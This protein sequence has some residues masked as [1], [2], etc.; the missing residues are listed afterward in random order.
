MGKYFGTD[1]IRG[2]ANN[3]L[4][5]SLAFKIGKAAA[6]VMSR[7]LN[8]R[9]VFLIG[10][11]T[12]ISGDML[13]AA[14]TA[15][16]CSAGGDVFIAGVIPTP[17][18]AFFVKNS[19]LYDSGIVISASHN[20]FYDNGI[21]FFDTNGCKLNDNIE[22]EIEHYIQ[23]EQSIK[24]PKP[25]EIGTRQI[26]LNAINEYKD[27]L[28]KSLDTQSLKGFK[29]VIDCANGATSEVAPMVFKELFADL[30]VVFDKPNGTNIN[31]NCGST[32]MERLQ[33]EVKDQKADL[34]IAYDGDGDRTLL[35][36]ENGQLIDG[37]KIMFIVANYLQKQNKLKNKG[38]VATVMSNYGLIQAAKEKD[39][40]LELSNVGD[41]YVL[42]KI[43]EKDYNFG[44][45]QSG[46]IIFFDY[47][48]S[49]DGIFTSIQLLNIM[50]KTNEK[51][52]KL[53]NEMN[54]MP[55]VLV[56]VKVSDNKKNDYLTN[57]VIC[58]KIK[59]VEKHLENS[60][61]ILV[62]ASGTE[63]LIRIMIE[64][65][66]KDYIIEEANKIAMLLQA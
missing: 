18:I 38:F 55:Q 32:H 5:P 13:E 7:S 28:K 34:G 47:N 43:I 3:I 1:G 58:D 54:T 66:N 40:K 21:K 50:Q 20:P 15:G 29:I 45:E 35:V 53:A 8:R 48:T 41:R 51:L 33:K 4:T 36:D 44:G 39:I 52:S 23:N 2:E 24:L 14:L 63:P 9:A 59:E 31:E 42:E 61:R 19:D 16:I 6:F 49:G 30:V 57:K 27:F 10:K 62:R 37:D 56:N 60:G 22:N 12:R 11:D 17:A 65:M 46:H 64:G 26:K 25:N